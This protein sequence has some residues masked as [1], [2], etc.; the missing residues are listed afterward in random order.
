MFQSLREN[1]RLNSFDN[2][3]CFDYGLGSEDGAVSLYTSKDVKP[4]GGLHE[5]LFTAY[6]SGNRDVYVQ[7]ILI[8]R[9]DDVLSENAVNRVDY[10]KI[11]AEG[12]ELF[13]LEGAQ[14][15]ISAC[16]P[17]LIDLKRNHKTFDCFNI[18][19]Q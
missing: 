18:L 16:K 14:D 6:P 7:R 2:V 4:H 10:I 5:G 3:S 19:C 12:A 11:D 8:R 13:V 15:I 17:K 1:I 9:L